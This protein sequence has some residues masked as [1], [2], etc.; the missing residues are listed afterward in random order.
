MAVSFS[1]YTVIPAKISPLICMPAYFMD[2]YCDFSFKQGE[3]MQG[4]YEK[5]ICNSEEIINQFEA[6]TRDAGRVQQ[7][8]L[9]KI[10]EANADAEYL[11]RFGLDGRTDAE[12][13]KTCIPLCVHSDIAPFIQRIVDGDTSP[14]ITGK[15]ITALSLRFSLPPNLLCCCSLLV[16]APFWR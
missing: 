4:Q 15:P 14:V 7:D 2:I 3:T 12:S 5:P 10:L 16:H 9:R 11:T 6:L 1:R 8:T 13:Y